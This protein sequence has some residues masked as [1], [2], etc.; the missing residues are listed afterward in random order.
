MILH[1]WNVSLENLITSA[2]E[3][4]Q[5]EDVLSVEIHC[6]GWV[7][8]GNELKTRCCQVGVWRCWW[9]GTGAPCTCWANAKRGDEGPVAIKLWFRGP[10][11]FCLKLYSIAVEFFPSHPKMEWIMFWDTKSHGEMEKAKGTDLWDYRTCA[12]DWSDAPDN[13]TYCCILK[14]GLTY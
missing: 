9:A 10:V 11:I 12:E 4:W 6:A 3:S 8:C 5:A 7:S 14:Y 13:T 2:G 1:F